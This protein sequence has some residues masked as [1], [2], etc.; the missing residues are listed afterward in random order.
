M[1]RTLIATALTLALSASAWADTTAA[2]HSYTP[3]EAFAM[4]ADGALL[5]AT[6]PEGDLRVT[7]VD[8]PQ[9][10]DAADAV[11]QA[12][13]RV[14][15]GFSRTLELSTARA[16]RNGWT[17]IQVFDYQTSPNEKLAVQATARR[18]VQGEGWLVVLL[19]GSQATLEKRSSPI[20]LF[21]GSLRPKGYERERFAGRT[22]KPLTPERIEQLKAFVERGM[23][24]L[25]VP[26][27]GLSFIDQGRVA[28]AGGLGVRRLGRPEPVDGDTLFMAASNTKSMTSA[29]MAQAVDAGRLRWDQPAQEVFPRFRLADA[30]TTRQVEVRHLVCACT[31][32]PRQDLDWLFSDAKAPAATTFEQLAQMKP[33]SR[34]GEV[35]QYSNLMVA[36]GG[37][38]AAA[39]LEPG[40]EVGAAYDRQMRQRLFQ[41]L[42]MTRT[43]FDYAQALAGNH[44]SPHG[45]DIDGVTRVAD[46]GLNRTIIPARPAGAVW[47]SPNDFSRWVLMELNKG[48]T[49]DGRPLISET[50]W[51]ARYQPQVM[52]GEDVHY[53][54][55][56]FINRQYGIPI[57]SHGGDMLGFH[58][59]MIWLPEHQMG[60]TILTN[61]DAGVLLRGP[62][63]RKFLEVVFDGRPEA[64]EQLRVSVANHRAELAKFKELYTL[65]VPA[66]AR[67][68]LAATYHHPALG[69]IRVA[70]R[71]DRVEF[72]A[73]DWR[74]QMAWRR[75]ADG[76]ESYNTIDPGLGGI[77]FV[78]DD[79][80]RP[81]ALV[82]RDA[83]HEYRLTPRR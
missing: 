72:L 75:N 5:S 15:P 11:A 54:L 7:L 18:P 52:V 51:A 28:W 50:N 6:A 83:Q 71:G 61:S 13:A 33:T 47:T 4:K 16:P 30:D 8:L 48:R 79:S 53:G 70:Q 44:A 2:G 9:A 67:R 40:K 35:F 77:E 82:L 21:I 57:A 22:P 23:R 68:A 76:S 59:N 73:R 46:M 39:A 12:W 19:E 41:P 69:T 31:G 49:P 43:T 32:L 74:S 60:L 80:T 62:L 27:V 81:A 64:D 20:S 38:I 26:G 3:P 56:L 10:K 63:L 65:P 25:Q 45:D 66:A 42:G 34:F 55:G 37:Y 17:D 78:R 14:K 24:E 29:L 58:S 1:R 36:A